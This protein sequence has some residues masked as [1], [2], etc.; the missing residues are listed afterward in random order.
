MGKGDKRS[1]K[2]KIIAGSSGKSRLKV[3]N[4]LRNA[5]R[6]AKAAAEAAGE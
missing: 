2:G 6:A 3:K 4:K 5:R 1:R